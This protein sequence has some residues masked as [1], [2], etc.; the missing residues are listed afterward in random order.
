MPVKGAF[1]A[2]RT[3]TTKSPA[4]VVV[5][6]GPGVLLRVMV[7]EAVFAAS[8]GMDKTP[9]T[10]QIAISIEVG[11]LTKLGVTTVAPAAEFWA[12]QISTEFEPLTALA[13]AET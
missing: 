2:S 5:T 1:N 9:E 8:R 12:Y 6:A 10:S 13:L 11:A 7:P 3:E 4:F